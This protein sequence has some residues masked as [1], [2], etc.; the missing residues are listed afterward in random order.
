M[1]LLYNV[2]FAHRCT[3]THHKIVLD[4]LRHLRH[5]EAEKWRKVFLKYSEHLLTGAKAPDDSFRD[6]RNHVLHVREKC[7]GGAVESAETWYKNLVESLQAKKWAEASY[8]AGVLSHYYSDPLMPLHTAQSEEAGIVRRA[9]SRSA[10]RSYD[11]LMAILDRD[12]GGYPN[13]K[14]PTGSRWLAEMVKTGARLAHEHYDVVIDH[15]DLAKGRWRAE[16]GLDDEI[17][18]SIAEC[19]AHAVVGFA[20]ILD[21]AIGESG[22]PAPKAGTAIRGLTAW[23]KIPAMN[24]ARGSANARDRR[25]VKAIFKEVRKTGKAIKALPED[26]RIVRELHAHEVLN[27]T[28]EKLDALRPRQIGTKHGTGTYLLPLV[29][30]KKFFTEAPT[31]STHGNGNSSDSD[32]IKLAADKNGPKSRESAEETPK[33]LE[34]PVPRLAKFHL[35]PSSSLADAPS[36][37]TKPAQKLAAVGIRTVSDLLTHEPDDIAARLK[38]GHVKPETVREWQIQSRLACRVPNLKA[39][40]VKILVACGISEPEELAQRQ[41]LDLLDHVD[42][43]V[44]TSEGQRAIRGGSQP[45]LDVVTGWIESARHARTLKA[46]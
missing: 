26:E 27:T 24:W 31:T 41:A 23:F 37:G 2:L 11:R 46:A 33:R 14:M 9:C 30:S 40:D 3:S 7:W 16:N 29:T 15:Y 22:V 8:S 4:A 32:A 13:V 12:L 35:D 28:L 10:F 17:R 44:S 34:K 6:Y 38:L 25:I 21:R 45:D 20:R 39:L 42:L 36:I 43:F 1:S 18:V 5:D 19:L